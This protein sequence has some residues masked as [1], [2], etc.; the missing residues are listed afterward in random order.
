MMSI[1]NVDCRTGRPRRYAKPSRTAAQPVAAP[2]TRSGGM[3]GSRT[4]AHSIASALTRSTAYAQERSNRAI[5]SPA[6]AGPTSA[7]ALKTTWFSAAAEGSSSTPISLGVIAAR[8]GELIADS[9]AS[10]ATAA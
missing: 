1:T 5:T 10:R 4:A 3:R 2:S 8:T 7:V 9:T 6:A